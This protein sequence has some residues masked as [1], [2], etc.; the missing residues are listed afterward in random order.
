MVRLPKE[1]LASPIATAK[2]AT[3]HSSSPKLLSSPL[4]KQRYVL[5]ACR[6]VAA[7]KLDCLSGSRKSAY[8][9]DA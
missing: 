9:Q 8:G 4:E 5:G 2:A 7:L 6:G 3:V 1:P